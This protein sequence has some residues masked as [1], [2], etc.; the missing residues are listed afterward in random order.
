MNPFGQYDHDHTQNPGPSPLGFV[1][2]QPVISPVEDLLTDL[3]RVRYLGC[4]PQDWDDGRLAMWQ[5]DHDFYIEAELPGDFSM[6]DLD[7]S[8]SSGKIFIRTRL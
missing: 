1:Q 5:D 3:D 2:H 8:I 7:I 6:Q 4:L